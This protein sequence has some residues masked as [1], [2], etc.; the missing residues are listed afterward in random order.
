MNG[1]VNTETTLRLVEVTALLPLVR[2]HFDI[3]SE[4]THRERVV[5]ASCGSGTVTGVLRSLILDARRLA[6]HHARLE[7]LEVGELEE[8]LHEQLIDFLI[9]S[10]VCLDVMIESFDSVLA[11]ALM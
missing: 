2:L 11:V 4:H 3:L 1:A 7:D 10:V 5:D 6:R 9:R 8:A